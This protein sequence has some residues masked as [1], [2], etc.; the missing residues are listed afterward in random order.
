VT[1]PVVP[2][3]DLQV[4]EPRAITDGPF[5]SNL[6]SRHYTDH[7]PR[8][9]RLQNIGDGSFIDEKAHISQEHFESLRTHEVVAGDLLVASLG[10]VLP[11]ACLAPP[12]LGPAIVKADCIRV[13]LHP[14]VDPRWVMYAMQRPEV[15]HWAESHRHGVGRP[16]LGLKMIREIP[17]PLPPLDEQR[18]IVALLE[19]HL[20]RL[21]A[22]NANVRSATQ[23]LTNVE[24]SALDRLF[25]GQDVPLADLVDN[26]SAGK[27]YGAANAPAAD[28]G[29]GIIKVSA[30]TWG[31]FDPAENKAVPSDRADPRFEIREGDLLVSRANTSEY[32]GASV[33]VG[34]VRPKL[35]L[36]DKSLRVSPAKS[37]RP[38][39]LWR[40]LQ[41]PSARHQISA[42]ATGTKDSMRNISQASLMRV[43]VPRATPQEQAAAVSAY[44]ETA[45][46]VNRLR[47]ELDAAGRRSA[48]L[49]RSLLAAAFSG[50]LTTERATA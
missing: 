23:R 50:Q 27:S 37:V 42:L 28:D 49:G 4:D 15:R 3:N 5:G 22:A 8:V 2:L 13:R 45:A 9:V 1:W 25:G 14:D 47:T 40:A 19:D 36:S 6:A 31:E 21:D 34:P 33:L 35:L 7:G 17:V 10:E 18:R 46:A 16:R 32:V 41:A 44:A 26:I 20:S 11:R 39:W 48:G 29:W 24:R 43:R 38:D 30:M 12:T